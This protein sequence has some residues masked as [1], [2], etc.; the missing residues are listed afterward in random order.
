MAEL[1]RS[2]VHVFT[3]ALLF[4]PADPKKESFMTTSSL[5]VWAGLGEET[6]EVII[7]NQDK[8]GR[9]VGVGSWYLDVELEPGGV[10]RFQ[11]CPRLYGFDQFQL[12]CERV[13]PEG[14][15]PSEEEL[16]A[17]VKADVSEEAWV[18]YR[19]KRFRVVSDW[20]LQI[21]SGELDKVPPA[22]RR[23]RPR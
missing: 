22:W 21:E 18:V 19:G 17:Q 20:G 9:I 16:L 11:H 15:P 13:R 6:G 12:R 3:N 1:P 10:L 5:G 7:L 4:R 2:D 8:P 23:R 14:P